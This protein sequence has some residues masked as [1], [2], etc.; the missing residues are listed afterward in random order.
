M[1]ARVV[2]ELRRYRE[3]HGFLRGLCASVGFKTTVIEYDREA[4]AEGKSRIPIR[5]AINIALDGIVPFSKTPVRLI[6]LGGV[7]LVLFAVLTLLIWASCT[8]A[9]GVGAHWAQAL[10]AI[11]NVFLTG[12]IL[13]GSGVLGE[14]TARSY[15]E[16]RDRP[17][18]IVDII[19]ESDTL[20]TK[21]RGAATKNREN[22]L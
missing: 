11:L 20:P 4:R 2:R 14:Y 12:V 5:G 15:E 21:L 16:T 3:R 22:C 18:Y 19:E 13:I 6:F 7:F 9:Q 1:D 10:S 8:I 17:R